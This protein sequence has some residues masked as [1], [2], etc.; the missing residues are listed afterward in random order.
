MLGAEPARA[1]FLDHA[2]ADKLVREVSRKYGLPLEP[3]AIIEDLPIGIQQRVEIVKAL[4]RDVDLLILDEPTAV[5]TPQETD[6][7]LEV[8]R[9]LKAA[10]QVDRLHHPQ[11]AR[12]QGGRRPDHRDPPRQ[13][14]RHRRADR[15]RVGAGRD[16]GRPQ[17]HPRGAQAGRRAG[18][19]GARASQGWSSPTTGC[20]ARSTA[21]TSRCGPVRCSASPGVQGNG[22]T[23]LVESI[24]GLAPGAGRHGHLPRQATSPTGT[25]ARCCGPG[26]G[27]MPEDRSVDGLV[28]EFSVA[29]N[30]V[31]DLYDTEP[32]GGRFALNPKAIDESAK[33]RVERVRH[34]HPVRA[35]AG[36]LA[37]RRQPAEGHRRAGDVTPA[38]AVHRR[39]ADPRRRRR[40]DRVHPPPHR[41][42]ARCRRRRACRLQRAGRGGGAGRPDRRD[43]PRPGARDRLARHATRD[44][45]P[46]D[47]R[48][49]P[50]ERTHDLPEHEPEAT[51]A[52]PDKSPA[53]RRSG[54]PYY[55]QDDQ[56]RQAPRR[57]RPSGRRCGRSSTPTTPSPSRC[58]RSCSPS[59][60]AA[61]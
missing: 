35:A 12:G 47:G 18:R 57:A 9:G 49:Y 58:S 44:A 48:H 10:G 7:L 59:S 24:M 27:Y 3:D 22:Q 19:A 1:G 2:T 60:S 15:A 34:P 61:C 55:M 16:D 25:P 4:T 6:E 37:V 23:E 51:A 36:R 26:V 13:D 52:S 11:A 30:L 31:L 21:S 28:K 41:R 42:R 46:A 20:T 40:L 43:V 8:M 29:E 14:R 17:R 39:P 54:R 5:L 33:G 32:F 50:G 53:H 45:R 56:A 38:E